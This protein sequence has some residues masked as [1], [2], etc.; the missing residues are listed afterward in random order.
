M[1]E[2]SISLDSKQVKTV[3]VGDDSLPTHYVN[4]I[5]VRSGL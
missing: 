1:T 2:E 5:N 3:F 4:I